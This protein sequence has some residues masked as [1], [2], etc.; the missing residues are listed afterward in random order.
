MRMSVKAQFHGQGAK[1]VKTLKMAFLSNNI[2]HP[3]L[4]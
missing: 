4:E 3:T 2:G 1:L